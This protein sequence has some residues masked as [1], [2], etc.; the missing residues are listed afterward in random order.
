MAALDKYH[1]TLVAQLDKTSIA[2]I[3][4]INVVDDDSN[5]GDAEKVHEYFRD[6]I[7]SE[8]KA[9]QS[10]RLEYECS[11]IRKLEPTSDPAYMYPMTDVGG[12]GTASLP[13]NLTM[14]VNTWS[15]DGRPYER[16]RW[17]FSGLLETQIEKGCWTQDTADD[18]AGF[19]GVVGGTYGELGNYYNLEHWSEAQE[20]FSPLIRGR[21]AAIPRKLRQ[22]TP[23]LCSIS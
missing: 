4:Y 17:F 1:L 15:G 16:G 10:S 23:G 13:S 2:N 19:L 5:P 22:R 7:V 18:W 6:N 11:L 9:L 12:L 20:T 14:C 3:F 8:L 21:L